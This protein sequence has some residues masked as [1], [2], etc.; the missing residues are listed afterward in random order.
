M[1]IIKT[2][3]DLD[4][5]KKGVVFVIEIYKITEQFPKSEV[6]GLSSQI[7]RASLSIPTN[8]AEGFGRNHKKEL[9]QF[10][11]IAMGSAAEI[12]TLLLIS[13]E[14]KYLTNVNYS[15]LSELLDHISRMLKNLSKSISNHD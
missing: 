5:W 9:L 12:D 7:R 10:L 14:L 8:I 6:Y 13:K 15:E 1:G 11:N 2:H 3:K 4:V